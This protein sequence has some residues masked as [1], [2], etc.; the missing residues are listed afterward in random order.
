M[1]TPDLARAITILDE[2]KEEA[3]KLAQRTGYAVASGL[4]AKAQE[5][6]NILLGEIPVDPRDN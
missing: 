4:H 5:V 3:E 2:I 1:E 6:Q